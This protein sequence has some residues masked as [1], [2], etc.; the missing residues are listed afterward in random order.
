MELA[1]HILQIREGLQAKRFVNEAAVSQGI[2]LRLL[3]ALGWP[4]YDTRIVAPEYSVEGRRVDFALCHPPLKPL[5][6]IEV[7]QVGQSSGADKQLFEYAFHEGVPMAVLTDGQEWNFYLPAEQGHYRDRR[8]YKLDLLERSTEESSELLSRY[9]NY[10]ASCAGD[11]LQA[12]RNDYRN[13]AREREIKATLPVAWEKLTTEPDELLLELLADKVE[14]LCGFKPDRHTVVTFLSPTAK[15]WRAPNKTL[16]A[17]LPAPEMPITLANTVR[18]L[19]KTTET[20]HAKGFYLFGQ[21]YPAQHAREVMSRLF[22]EINQ[23]QPD[24]LDRFAALPKHGKKRRYIARLQTDLYP[25][26]PDLCETHAYRLSNGWWMG[27]NNSKM[28]TEKIIKLACQVAGLSYGVDV[29]IKL[30]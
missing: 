18:P 24:F 15:S 6:F 17:P 23:S 16:A 1:S 19:P 4:T 20:L 28:S 5:I 25:N 22:E 7:K 26:R 13:I 10:Q 27:T 14:S 9:L 3:M 12:A 30:D 8:V 11:A 21:A 29:V 2:V